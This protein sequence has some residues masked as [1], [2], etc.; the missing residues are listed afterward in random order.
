MIYMI[1]KYNWEPVLIQWIL[2]GF[3]FIII[4]NFLLP[5]DTPLITKLQNQNLTHKL[6]HLNWKIFVY[7]PLSN[8]SILLFDNAF[9]HLQF[10]YDKNYCWL[11]VHL[12][13][14]DKIHYH[15]HYLNMLVLVESGFLAIF[16]WCCLLV[17]L[18]ATTIV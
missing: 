3:G 16:G 1:F 5:Y 10:R 13:I 4:L 7:R 15:I 6:T 14:L 9:L 12:T 2:I 17:K 8:M 18:D 11:Y